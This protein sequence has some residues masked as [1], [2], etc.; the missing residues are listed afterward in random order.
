MYLGLIKR[1]LFALSGFFLM[2]YLASALNT[3]LFG[4]MIVI[5]WVTCGFDA[6]QI[7]RRVNA[8]EIIEDNVDDVVGFIKRNKTLFILIACILLGSAVIR[9][10]SGFM[11]SFN[12]YYGYT[13]RQGFR[14]I[15]SLASGLFPL[16][17]I[18]AGLYLLTRFL[19]KDSYKPR[20]RISDD[21]RTDPGSNENK[22][23]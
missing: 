14:L 3:P 2:A 9:T 21:Y 23:E 11:E 17:V 13:V 20:R 7:R 6:F 19:R 16:L 8:G 15:R 22:E 18:G 12:W 5:L 4:M 1:G 10:L